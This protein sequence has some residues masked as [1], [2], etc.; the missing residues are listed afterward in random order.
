[1]DRNAIDPESVAHRAKSLLAELDAIE[2]GKHLLSAQ[3]QAA[4]DRLR[5]GLETV[6]AEASPAAARPS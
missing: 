6:V 5:V 3:D 4:W 2:H 1:M